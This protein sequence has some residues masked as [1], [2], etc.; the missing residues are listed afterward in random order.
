VPKQ[1]AA[2]P[3]PAIPSDLLKNLISAGLLTLPASA[4]AP[5]LAQTTVKQEELT[6]SGRSEEYDDVVL[7]MDVQLTPASIQRQVSLFKL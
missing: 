2:A 4:Q 5:A 1:P 6:T 3:L 7:G